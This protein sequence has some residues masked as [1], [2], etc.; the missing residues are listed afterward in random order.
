MSNSKGNT[1]ASESIS[2][3]EEKKKV[4][5]RHGIDTNE[6]RLA[7]HHNSINRTE[8]QPGHNEA[9]RREQSAHVREDRV[10]SGQGT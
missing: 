10:N 6:S 7:F 5:I 4:N 2:G 8:V 1:E 9:L 3:S